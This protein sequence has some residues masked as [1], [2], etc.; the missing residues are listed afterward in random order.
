MANC[1]SYNKKINIENQYSIPSGL[2]LNFTDVSF[3]GLSMEKGER[4]PDQSVDSSSVVRVITDQFNV[5]NF[6]SF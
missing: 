3:S 5:L 2:Y 1:A 6:S 4:A